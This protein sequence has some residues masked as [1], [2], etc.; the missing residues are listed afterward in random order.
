VD[1]ED[2]LT[3]SHNEVFVKQNDEKEL[4]VARY[5]DLDPVIKEIKYF[6]AKGK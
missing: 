6:L 3:A 2:I 5:F 1:R 4:S